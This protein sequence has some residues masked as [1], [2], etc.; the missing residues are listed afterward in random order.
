MATDFSLGSVCFIFALIL[1]GQ[2]SQ[3][4]ITPLFFIGMIVSTAPV[5]LTFV[6]LGVYHSLVRFITGHALKA[7]AT[8]VVMGSVAF[9]LLIVFSNANT[10]YTIPL[11]YA[12]LL[13]LSTAAVRFLIRH[14]FRNPHQKTKQSA[15]IY[16][17]GKNGRELQNSLIDNLSVQPVA[18]IDDNAS[19]QG[20]TIGGLRVY[21]LK[22]FGKIFEKH[23]VELV[24]LALPTISRQRRRTI[25]DYFQA[26][27]IQLK[28]IPSSVKILNGIA[29][30]SELQ[31]F[32]PEMLL[33]RTPMAPIHALMRRNILDKS[34]MVSGA[35]GSIGSEI[36]RQVLMQNPSRIILFDFSEYALYLINEELSELNKKMG[37][38]VTIVPVLGSVC[39][40]SKVMET[41][42]TFEVDTIYHAAAY[43]H[44]PLVEENVIEGINNNIFGTLNVAAAA[45]ELSVKNLMLIST[46]KAVRPTNVMGASKRV[47]E[48]ICQAYAAE[49]GG[50]TTFSMVRFGNVLGSSGSVIP[51]FQSQI[52]AGGPVTVTDPE[53]KRYFM[54][55]REAS[56]LVIQ[57]SA[58]AKGG[59]VFVLDMGTLVKITDLAIDLIRF[60]GFEHYFTDHNDETKSH[61]EKIPICF[62]G[63]RT[64]EK[65][66]EELLISNNPKPTKHVRIMKAT[67]GL[68][69]LRE[70]SSHLDRIEAACGTYNV[71]EVLGILKELPIDFRPND[72][73]P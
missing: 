2:S 59:E 13:F 56:E 41:V 53:V 55:L 3:L 18:F 73:R 68:L 58:M 12:P 71:P 25:F 22:S 62:T 33:G 32:S 72:S 21:P 11:I 24:L 14:L 5:L 38:A 63:L 39:N 47:A 30:I 36:C 50:E 35:G 51:L 46:D 43:K 69:P 29:E 16:G 64:G 40:K 54:T 10:P 19:I 44:L 57:A 31:P 7:I 28:T 42:K 49:K 20:L 34:V 65:L 60:A 48:L 66:Q 61:P 52:A 67:E 70:L 17:A 8:G 6:F 26:Y 4:S 27:D 15:V 45:A 1:G 9:T 23:G 37:L